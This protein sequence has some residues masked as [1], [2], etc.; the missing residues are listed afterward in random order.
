MASGGSENL[1]IGVRMSNQDAVRS[2]EQLRGK[3]RQLET[4]TRGAAG[5]S[6][7]MGRNLTDGGRAGAAALN[8][9]TGG[10]AKLGSAL[11]GVFSVAQVLR[12][13]GTVSR[14][15][16]RIRR[17]LEGSERSR[18]QTFFGAGISSD[19][20]P[21]FVQQQDRMVRE[22][23]GITREGYMRA[24][25]V[26]TDALPTSSTEERLSVMEAMLTG[27][28]RRLSEGERDPFILATA[29]SRR[30]FP[31]EDPYETVA[32][33][34]RLL[35]GGG[36]AASQVTESRR[37]FQTIQSADPTADPRL[38]R[39]VAMA[40]VTAFAVAGQRPSG[41]TD[42]A[43]SGL[44]RLREDRGLGSEGVLGDLLS[45]LS[46]GMSADEL[47]AIFPGETGATRAALFGPGAPL[48]QDFRSRFGDRSLPASQISQ[49][50]EL[51][52]SVVQPSVEAGQE[53]AR[54]KAG[55]YQ[56]HPEQVIASLARERELAGVDLQS[57]APFLPGLSGAVEAVAGWGQAARGLYGRLADVHPVTAGPAYLARRGEHLSQQ[58][59]VNVRMDRP[60]D[61]DNYDVS[62]D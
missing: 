59:N 55:I 50:L 21:R 29:E 51:L 40:G 54:V 36:S 56:G 26:F 7:Q 13:F 17:E 52:S 3:V 39:D 35:Q 60:D 25:G 24:L 27:P 14:E 37:A 28:L 42:Q 10:V 58:I 6:R 19:E 32:R 41:L 4:Q 43:L 12:Y 22:V 33:V 45:L 57:R 48:V 47:A 34:I 18:F 46:G 30:I 44:L 49:D 1:N 11:A 23:A 61:G 5:Q 53:G 15:L 62:I 9:L 16:D 20:A 2:I 38:L 31:G 8:T